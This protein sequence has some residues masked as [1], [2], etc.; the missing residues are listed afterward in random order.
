MAKQHDSFIDSIQGW[1]APSHIQQNFVLSLNAFCCLG[2]SYQSL[3]LLIPNGMVVSLKPIYT[4]NLAWANEPRAWSRL[5][6]IGFTLGRASRAGIPGLLHACVAVWMLS[7]AKPQPVH[8]LPHL[9][10]CHG[11]LLFW[12]SYIPTLFQPNNWWCTWTTN[13]WLELS[14]GRRSN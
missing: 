11:E 6:P 2:A 4:T 12:S 7:S 8:L 13:N 3:H 14:F 10:N 5:E 9:S 1:L